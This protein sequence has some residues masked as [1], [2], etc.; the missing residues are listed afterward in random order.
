[1][2]LLGGRLIGVRTVR[3]AR[4]AAKPTRMCWCD[5][6]PTGR[7]L[8]DCPKT[9]N[10]PGR[11]YR[12]LTARQAGS[13]YRNTMHVR[14][15]NLTVLDNGQRLAGHYLP[16]NDRRNRDTLSPLSSSVPR[17]VTHGLHCR[18]APSQQSPRGWAAY[19][20]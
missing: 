14:S 4:R 18:P 11:Q 2:W 16:A 9:L 5:F 19:A 3:K 1:V 6:D 20:R 8:V 13:D 10:P 12:I 17:R 7:E 15:N